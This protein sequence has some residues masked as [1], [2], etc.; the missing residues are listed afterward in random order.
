MTAAGV[1][2]VDPLR[3]RGAFYRGTRASCGPAPDAGLRFRSPASTV[4]LRATRGHIGAG[5]VLP[6]LNL[7]TTGAKSGEP[8]TAT[9]LYFSDGDDVIVIASS[10][11]R[12]K[13]RPGTTTSRPTPTPRSSAPVARAATAQS[14]SRTRPSASVSSACRQHL[15]RLRRLPRAH[16]EDR[17]ADSRDAPGAGRLSGARVDPRRRGQ[18]PRRC[19][20]LLR[21]PRERRRPRPA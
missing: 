5:L 19:R 17:A 2:R 4:L 14:R 20:E 3:P 12:D 6:S 9:V 16:R 10:F 1:P 18:L 15:R 13:H 11:G 7:T 8:R 21:Q